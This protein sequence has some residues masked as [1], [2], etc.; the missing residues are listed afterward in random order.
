MTLAKNLYN[1]LVEILEDTYDMPPEA[2][3]LQS[4]RA[5]AQRF[6]VSESTSRN[7]RRGKH[8][9]IA[10]ST[11]ASIIGICTEIAPERVP[12]LEFIDRLSR[13]AHEVRLA[14]DTLVEQLNNEVLSDKTTWHIYSG[15]L[16]LA[17]DVNLDPDTRYRQMMQSSVIVRRLLEMGINQA[18]I[19]AAPELIRYSTHGWY[20]S[21]LFKLREDSLQSEVAGLLDGYLSPVEAALYIGDGCVVSSL[22]SGNPERAT[23]YIEQALKLLE[24]A[25]PEDE[26]FAA[27]T[28]RDA[29]TMIWS[30]QVMVACHVGY[31]QYEG[32]IG[33][34][35]REYGSAP[36]QI[37]WIEGHRQEALGYIDLAKG[38]DYPQAA[39]HFARAANSLTNWLSQ[40]GIPFSSTSSQS[41]CGYAR[42]MSEGPTEPVKSQISEGLLRTI[43][44]GIISHQIRARL[45]Q[46]R[47]YECAGDLPMATFQRTKIDELVQRH[48]LH[49]WYSMMERILPPTIV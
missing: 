36:A 14:A 9:Q 18:N 13:D 2:G 4:D 29:A 26:K 16:K 40:F 46:A 21:G 45:C 27:V 24:T 49:R 12:D 35:I 33:K 15:P 42:L 37:E 11:M 28:I 48:N 6:G 38:V 8:G 41:L 17:F 43:D 34:F 10:P 7:W 31:A 30:L 22:I 3:L 19:P 20:L 32:M 5:I 47:F 25:T 1:T 23:H 39:E 44:L